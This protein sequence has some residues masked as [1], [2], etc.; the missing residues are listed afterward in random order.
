MAEHTSYLIPGEII[1][2][3]GIPYKYLGDGLICGPVDVEIAR[4]LRNNSEE[5]AQHYSSDTAI[6]DY[7]T[8]AVTKYSG[9]T[10]DSK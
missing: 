9:E 5:I 6:D 10:H 1:K 2:I 4:A 3:S 7:Y 8:S